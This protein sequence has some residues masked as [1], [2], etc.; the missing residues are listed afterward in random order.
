MIFNAIR[1]DDASLSHYG[2][3]GMKWG[4]RNEDTL[5]RYGLLTPGTVTKNTRLEIKNKEYL[6]N[7]GSEFPSK[8]REYSRMDDVKAVNPYMTALK[9]DASVSAFFKSTKRDPY[10]GSSQALDTWKDTYE[11]GKF[12]GAR[13]NCA[14]CSVV[15]DLRQRG[16]DVVASMGNT[17]GTSEELSKCYPG[18]TFSPPTDG[19]NMMIQ[20]Q[21]DLHD[22]ETARGI[23][24]YRY[25]GTSNG[26][27]IAF[28]KEN[29]EYKYYDCQTGEDRQGV[30]AF[31]VENFQYMRTDDLEPDL[32]YIQNE[33][34]CMP[35]PE[36][37]KQDEA[38]DESKPVIEDAAKKI[39]SVSNTISQISIC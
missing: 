19:L 33:G 23:I 26:H 18:G 1:T 15:F 25:T 14:S 27:A 36:N 37:N 13:I 8:T 22:M 28:V 32:E 16:Y 24:T 11:N 9:T 12:S 35:N 39:R 30:P 31:G 3:K 2:V 20:M 38:E 10:T 34:A 29:G 17:I 5:V 21:K 6:K 7:H 4:V